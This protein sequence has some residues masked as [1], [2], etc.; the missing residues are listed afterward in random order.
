M[1]TFK[2]T[3]TILPMLLSHH[4]WII[5]TAV[6]PAWAKQ[7]IDLLQTVQN[8]AARLLTRTKKHYHTSPFLAALHWLPVCFRIDFTDHF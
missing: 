4:V 7:S 3:E 8:S 5:V 1:L 2:N 6:L